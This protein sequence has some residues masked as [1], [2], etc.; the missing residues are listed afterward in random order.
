ML[1]ELLVLTGNQKQAEYF[2]DLTIKDCND[3][4]GIDR[5][6]KAWALFQKACCQR[7]YELDKSIETCKQILDEYSDCPW[8]EVAKAKQ[9][10]LNWYQND[11]PNELIQQC[12]SELK[13]YKNSNKKYIPTM[14]SGE[15]E[16]LNQ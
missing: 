10:L 5:N 8:A 12:R 15:N 4:D 6:D 11:K 1:A 2:Y 3:S 9:E 7:I 16:P 14:T 13:K